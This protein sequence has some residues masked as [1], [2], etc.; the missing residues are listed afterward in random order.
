M[1]FKE[2]I[3]NVSRTNGLFQYAKAY[4]E[5]NDESILELYLEE[6]SEELRESCDKAGS[7]ILALV[8]TINSEYEMEQLVKSNCAEVGRIYWQ[9]AY[10]VWMKSYVQTFADVPAPQMEFSDEVAD[11]FERCQLGLIDNLITFQEQ[12]VDIRYEAEW[13][14]K[15]K[16]VFDLFFKTLYDEIH[17]LSL[18]SVEYAITGKVE[19]ETKKSVNTARYRFRSSSGCC[20]RCAALDGKVIPYDQ[21]VEG[22]NYPLIHPNCQCT[23]E[24]VTVERIVAYGAGHLSQVL[25]SVYV[26]Q[27]AGSLVLEMQ[28]YTTADG[29]TVFYAGD[30]TILSFED[31]R[32]VLALNQMYRSFSIVGDR[33]RADAV[34]YQIV[35]IRQKEQYKGRYRQSDEDGVYIDTY[36]YQNKEDAEKYYF[37]IEYLDKDKLFKHGGKGTPA[38]ETLYTLMSAMAGPPEKSTPELVKWG[39][40]VALSLFYENSF[41]PDPREWGSADWVAN[42]DKFMQHVFPDY[43]PGDILREGD[44]SIYMGTDATAPALGAEYYFR[45]QQFL[46]AKD[47]KGNTVH[48]G[49]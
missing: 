25:N 40:F 1:Y 39:F 2:F 41:D 37:N 31:Y 16:K 12:N 30:E 26:T 19:T 47:Q 46:Y 36:Q 5:E 4:D 20:A 7:T 32:T 3:G 27:N 17:K 42:L 18:M 14:E 35:Q 8:P 43:N 28:S 11:R 44:V 9:L 24:P 6:K 48:R 10:F 13:L 34:K 38:Q 23:V 21:A 45:E 15:G 33:L 29:R 22:V 49:K